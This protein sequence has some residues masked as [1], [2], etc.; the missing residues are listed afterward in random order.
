MRARSSILLAFLLLSLPASASAQTSASAWSLRVRAV[1]SGS[2][3]D[4]ASGGYTIYSGFALE[5]AVVRR[6]SDAFALELALRTESREVE[7]PEGPG[8]RPP[9]GS[10]EVLPLT[11]SAQWRPRGSTDASWQPYVGAGVNV[12]AV[13]EKSGAL[14]SSNLSPRVGPAVV[15]GSDWRLTDR[16]TL[17]LDVRWNTLTLEIDDFIQPPPSVKVDPLAI[18]LG[19]GLRF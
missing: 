15:L 2:S 5:A 19:V 1:M 9:L 6:V 10:L 18:G 14:D 13:W 16:S 11:L 17:N 3:D 7:G 4:A 8:G 12:T